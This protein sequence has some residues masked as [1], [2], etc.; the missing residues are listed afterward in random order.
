[1]KR[2]R[3][4]GMALLLA[5]A[6]CLPTPVRDKPL[7]TVKPSPFGPTQTVQGPKRE[8]TPASKQEALRVVITGQKLVEAN[9]QVGLR[10]DFQTIGAPTPELFHQGTG[11]V[12][13]TEAL[14]QQCKTEGQ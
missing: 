12:V 5:P 3:A 2:L 11:S 13:I 8:L 6:G 7:E 4:M 14:S 1:M 10:P 9:R